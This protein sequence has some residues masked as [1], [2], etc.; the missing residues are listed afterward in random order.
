[1]GNKQIH[2]SIEI[3]IDNFDIE[4]FF[5]SPLRAGEY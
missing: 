3:D 5:I 4:G 1:M 2:V